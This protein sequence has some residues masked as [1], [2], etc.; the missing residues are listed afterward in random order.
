[1][2]ITYDDLAQACEKWRTT[3]PLLLEEKDRRIIFVALA[4]AKA[5]IHAKENDYTFEVADAKNIDLDPYFENKDL[6]YVRINSKMIDV[7]DSI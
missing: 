3:I 6:E 7:G 1:M 2:A 4:A 5:Q